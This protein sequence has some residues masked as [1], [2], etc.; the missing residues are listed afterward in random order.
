MITMT[1][2]LTLALTLSPSASFALGQAPAPGQAPPIAPPVDAQ[3]GQSTPTSP[4]YVIGP[5]DQLSITVF[6]EPGLTGTYRVE[7]DGFFTFPLLNRVRAGGRSL[8]ELQTALTA[9]LEN[10]F[11]RNPQVRVEIDAYKS[12]SVIV[13]G[14]VRTPGELTMTSASMTLL[15]A[16]AQA[17]SPTADASNEV[18][19]QRRA[20]ANQSVGETIRVNRRELELGRAGHDLVLRDGDIIHVPKAETF[21]VDGH[22]RNPGAYV[23][24]PGITVQQ[25]IALA[26]GLSERGSDRGIVVNRVVNGKAQDVSVRLGDRVQPNDTIKI[27]AR[28]F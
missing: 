6:D 8:A 26:G 4:S 17:G 18:I 5:Q 3:E 27:R 10:G 16:L 11:L 22:V 20:E 21:F 9:M 7:N 2:L 19:V 1:I 12:Q 24:D 25:A 28:F 23:F 15:Q 14:Q 13:T